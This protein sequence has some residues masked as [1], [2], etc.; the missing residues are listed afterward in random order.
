MNK[1]LI[2]DDEPDIT[3][4]FDLLGNYLGY[5]AETINSGKK[6][7]EKLGKMD[8]SYNAVFCDL[9]MP[10]IDGLQIYNFVSGLDP[11]FSR[12]FV[13]LTGAILDQNVEKEIN[14][15]NIM[16]LKKPF[17]ID[18]IKKAIEIIERRQ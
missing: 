8:R 7:L 15:K 3:E 11:E 18:E 4:I 13:L 14:L 12:R 6:A 10:G 5:T 9:K 2:I 16:V 1:L 17:A